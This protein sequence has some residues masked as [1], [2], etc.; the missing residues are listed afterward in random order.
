MTN[1]S[2]NPIHPVFVPSQNKDLSLT[3]IVREQGAL[4]R[5]LTQFVIESIKTFSNALTPKPLRFSAISTLKL[6]VEKAQTRKWGER[7]RQ[8][9]KFIKVITHTV[10]Q[11]SAFHNLPL[12][13]AVN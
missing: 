8:V 3:H 7:M 1:Q 11:K 4:I 6:N 9:T 13:R 10:P 2:L 5:F 12:F